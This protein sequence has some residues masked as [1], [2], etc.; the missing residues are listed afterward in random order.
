MAN[1]V[2]INRISAY[3]PFDPVDNEQMEER[4]GLV[5]GQPSRARRLVLK[6]NG[7][8][9]RHYVIDPLSGE[10][11]MNNAQISAAAIRGLEAPG[12]DLG[13]LDCLVASL[14]LIHI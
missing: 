10:P 3:L 7:I 13:E 11:A 12:F 14:S 1:P 4:L 8:Q 9:S 6:R 2:F 5:G